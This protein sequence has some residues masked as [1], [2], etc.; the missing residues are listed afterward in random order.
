MGDLDKEELKAIVADAV[1]AAQDQAHESHR[2]FF[3]DRKEHY[4][5]HGFIGGIITLTGLVRKTMIVGFVGM[6]VTGLMALVALG[7][8]E[9]LR[10][11][12]GG[13]Q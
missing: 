2:E 4:E 13:V 7:L 3:I 6:F 1:V 5:H 8:S 9:R 12:V 10:Q 11:I